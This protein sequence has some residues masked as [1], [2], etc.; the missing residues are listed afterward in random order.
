MKLAESFMKLLHHRELHHS[1]LYILNF[2][3]IFWREFPYRSV[4][5]IATFD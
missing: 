5:K 2:M 3:A 4:W 1:S